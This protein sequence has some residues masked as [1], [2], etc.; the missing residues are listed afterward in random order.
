M[1]IGRPPQNIPN[2]YQT[3]GV[4]RTASAAEIKKAFRDKAISTHPDRNPDLAAGKITPEEAQNR[5]QAIGEAYEILKDPAKREEY[6]LTGSVGGGAG[7]GG[8]GGPGH[9]S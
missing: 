5:F 3:L 6:D 8:P 9:E 2:P 7:M 4:S 1:Q